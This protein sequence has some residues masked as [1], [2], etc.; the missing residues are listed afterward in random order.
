MNLDVG[1]AGEY[2]LVINR[3]DGSQTDTGW[4]PNIILNQGLDRLGNSASGPIIRYAH[5][6]TGT[7]TPTAV[8]TGLDSF[9]A[10]A[11]SSPTNY[12][13]SCVNEGAPSYAALHT[14]RYNFAQGAVVGNITEIG[15][16][17]GTTGNTLFSRAL[18]LDGTGSPTTITLV[19]IDQLT[20]YYRLRVVPTLTD[21]TG[22]INIS[23]TNYNYVVRMSNVGSFA[24][25]QFL[26]N[27]HTN[28]SIADAS[29]FIAY[30]STSVLG[31]VTSQ[32]SGTTPTAGTTSNGSYTAGTYYRDITF[33]FSIS[34][35][36]ASGG[37]GA[38]RYIMPTS[39]SVIQFQMSFSPAIPKD[40][41]KT[42]SMVMRY[43]W[44]RL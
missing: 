31:A 15:V 18:I 32:P 23:G 39:Y 34:Q 41:T 11:D 14:W 42:F 26:F 19:A 5:V 6:G 27:S 8:Q 43:S 44:S 25:T 17:W 40:N 38:V 4:F 28:F 30:P 33:N 9:M 16:G 35:G 12:A 22:T 21:L 10:A 1:L 36:N 37:I 29:G 2:R 24:T 13:E 20:V 7:S 3:P